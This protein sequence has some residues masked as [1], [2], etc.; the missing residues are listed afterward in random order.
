MRAIKRV[1][2]VMLMLVAAAPGT[3]LAQSAGDE[4]Y[5]DPFQEPPTRSEGGQGGGS[6]GGSSGDSTGGGGGASGV[7]AGSGTSAPAPAV[8]ET[9]PPVTEAA[10]GTTATPAETSPVLPR[11]GLPLAPVAALGLLLVIG[12]VALRRRT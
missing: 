1:L 4:Q 2:A 12:G 9:T 7:E 6:Q 8:E 5:I 3:A 10:P 11:T